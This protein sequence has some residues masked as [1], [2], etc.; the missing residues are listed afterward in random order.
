MRQLSTYLQS[1]K[2]YHAVNVWMRL[3]DLVKVLL[4]PDINVEILRP[5]A[6]DKL[7]AIDDFFRSVIEVVHNHDLVVGL[8]QRKSGKGANVAASSSSQS[9]A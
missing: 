1:S 5:L 6:A 9:V 4:F 3:E 8:Q 7:N 2:M